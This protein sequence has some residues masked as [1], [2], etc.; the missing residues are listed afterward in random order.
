MIHGILQFTLRIAFRCV[1]HRC[2]SQDIRCSELSRFSPQA[3][4]AEKV[5]VRG[6]SWV[7]KYSDV[8]EASER[9][10]FSARVGALSRGAK[11]LLPSSGASTGS[12][13]WFDRF[14]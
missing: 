9:I 4:P 8:A 11:V 13:E 3:V 10:F 6:L 5:Q 12:L 14:Q 7:E 1:L 2:E